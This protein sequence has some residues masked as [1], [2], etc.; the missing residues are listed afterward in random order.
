MGRN[1]R[2]LAAKQGRDNFFRGALK[3]GMDQVAKGGTRGLLMGY[4]RNVHVPQSV[5][6]VPRRPFLFKHSQLRPYRGI[7]Q[8]GLKLTADFRDGGALQPV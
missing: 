1:A 7:A 3:K 6:F 8:L 4:R 2:A 5:F